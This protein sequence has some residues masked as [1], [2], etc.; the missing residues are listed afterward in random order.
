M[1]RAK[2]AALDNM[3]RL[4]ASLTDK[5]VL[6]IYEAETWADEERVYVPPKNIWLNTAH[7]RALK[8]FLNEYLDA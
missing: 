2:S 6:T 3:G 7:A 8:N 5:G 1:E 4:V